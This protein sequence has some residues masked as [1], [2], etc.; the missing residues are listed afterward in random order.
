MESQLGVTMQQSQYSEGDMGYQQNL[1]GLLQM[2]GNNGGIQQPQN[3]NLISGG[4][5]I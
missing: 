2:I 4:G 3:M 5:L 1:S